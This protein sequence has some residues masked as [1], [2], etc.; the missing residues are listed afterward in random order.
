MNSG[1]NE[2]VQRETLIHERDRSSSDPRDDRPAFGK[3]A[4]LLQQRLAERAEAEWRKEAEQARREAK[5][6][7]VDQAAIDEAVRKRRYGQS[8]RRNTA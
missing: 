2:V 6:C 1:R 5:A 4:E 7:G 3:R 8:E